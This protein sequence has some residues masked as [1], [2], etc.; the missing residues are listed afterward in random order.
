[1]DGYLAILKEYPVETVVE[2]IKEAVKEC[3]YFPPPSKIITHVKAISQ[4]KRFV[5]IEEE[6]GTEGDHDRAEVT[7]LLSDFG[8]RM[9]WD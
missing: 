7:K 1:M 6:V 3:D 4:R 8:K 9:N 5:E 2:A